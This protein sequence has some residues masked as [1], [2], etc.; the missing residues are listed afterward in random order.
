LCRLVPHAALD[1]FL[2]EHRGCGDLDGGADGDVIWMNC[3][4]GA[5]IAHPVEPAE[6]QPAAGR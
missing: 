1:A 4:C 3:D 6:Q 2:R 5:G